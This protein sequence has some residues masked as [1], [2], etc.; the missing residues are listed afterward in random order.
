MQTEMQDRDAIVS[1]AIEIASEAVRSAY[2]AGACG[3]DAALRQ[4]IE[5]RVAAHFQG[6]SEHAR[7][8]HTQSQ[9]VPEASKR[10][11]QLDLDKETS[12]AMKMGPKKPR[13]M[14]TV[15]ALLLLPATV[16]GAG[17]TA[18]KMRGD[19]PAEAKLQQVQQE[20]DQ[21]RKAEAD[22]KKQLEKVLEARGL[23]EGERDQA[24]AAE[25]EARLSA[26]DAKAVLSFLQDNVFLAAGRPQ[27]WSGAGLGKDVTLRKAVDQAASKVTGAFPDRPMVEAAIREILGASY[28]DLGD[29]DQAVKQYEQAFKLLESNLGLEHPET[30]DCRDKLAV[31]YREAGRTDEASRL[32]EL[33]V[34]NT[35]GV[36]A[37][38][39]RKPARGQN[40]PPHG[41]RTPASTQPVSGHKGQGS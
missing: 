2:I 18:W 3:N 33:S 5:E 9:E 12:E 35:K 23:L 20:R 22:L 19:D 37:M 8:K 32:F 16:G 34:S 41:A 13:G 40:P 26:A 11:L 30:V 1:N 39:S 28:R 31:V 25:K 6:G 15:W 14:M 27:S 36:E 7:A 29:A 10:Y 24:V 4:Q 21:A 17:L 38:R